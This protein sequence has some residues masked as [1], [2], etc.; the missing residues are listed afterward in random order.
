VGGARACCRSWLVG[1]ISFGL[2]LVIVEEELR[3]VK[4][5]EEL[6]GACASTVHVPGPW[7]DRYDS[8]SVL[9]QRGAFDEQ[10]FDDGYRTGSFYF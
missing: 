7:Y 8:Y 3:S 10:L 2:F 9:V 4:C 6:T 5:G 1:W